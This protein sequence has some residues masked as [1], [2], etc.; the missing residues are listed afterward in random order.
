MFD[1]GPLGSAPQYVNFFLFV[2]HPSFIL[3]ALTELISSE[4]KDQFNR[5][6]KEALWRGTEI[7]SEDPTLAKQISAWK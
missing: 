1:T 5:K 2:R 6:I 7:Y 3:C 4:F